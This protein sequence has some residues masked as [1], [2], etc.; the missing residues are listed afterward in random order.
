MPRIV[1]ATYHSLEFAEL[2][3]LLAPLGWEALSPDAAGAADVAYSQGGSSHRQQAENRARAFSERAGLPALAIATAF[4]VY[5]LDQGPG[6]R[7]HDY[8]GAAATDGEHRAKL[9]A[10]IKRVPTGQRI[11]LFQA[12]VAFVLP[13]E[14]KARVTTS[15]LECAIPPEER[16][17]GG[18]LYDAVTQVQDR[19]TLAEMD[20]DE[21]YRLG[22]RGM[23]MKQMGKFLVLTP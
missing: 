12:S 2:S 4:Q 23:A 18:Y 1:V 3:A 6:L 14:E 9:L 16:G 21:R 22:H 5:A 15:T 17:T 20:D 11:A 10:A 7:T 8:A 13:G 19:K